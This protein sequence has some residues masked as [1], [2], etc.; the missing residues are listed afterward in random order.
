MDGHG[1]L[2]QLLGG[3]PADS[4]TAL[5]GLQSIPPGFLPA[6][7][8]HLEGYSQL[9]I[10]MLTTDTPLLGGRFY[11]GTHGCSLRL[12]SE[13][14][15]MAVHMQEGRQDF[16]YGPSYFDLLLFSAADC[17]GDRL[18]VVLLSGAETGNLEG[19]RYMRENGG[20][21]LIQ[22]RSTCMMPAALAAAIEENLC[23]EECEPDNICNRIADEYHRRD[24][25]LAL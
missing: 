16:G 9:P 11:L 25:H 24:S 1:T 20:R 5:I 6:L 2:R 4:T 12:N 13:R 17:F 22:Q 19:L 18:Q 8:I 3:L 23:D 14:G 21:L 15:E 7:A 10:N